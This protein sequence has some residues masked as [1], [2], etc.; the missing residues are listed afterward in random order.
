MSY[1]YASDTIGIG[2]NLTPQSV[3]ASIPPAEAPRSACRIRD[4]V[5]FL[6]AKPRDESGTDQLCGLGSLP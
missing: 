4:S 5:N 2:F 6:L 3:A 1:S